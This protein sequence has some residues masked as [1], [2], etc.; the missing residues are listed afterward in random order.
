MRRVSLA[1][2]LLVAPTIAQS[3]SRVSLTAS[4]AQVSGGHADA[5][6]LS[7]DGRYVAFF[8]QSS[9]L[10]T[11]DANNREDVFVHDRYTGAIERLSVSNA[12]V[13]GNGD[14]SFPS[15]S[16]DG[17]FV[18]F[19]SGA[20][21]FDPVPINN[22]IDIYLR[23]RQLGTT[24]LVS[25][26]SLG[27]GSD[28]GHSH[29]PH[30]SADGLYVAFDSESNDFVTGD[31]NAKS[32]IFVH[33]RVTGTTERLSLS[34]AGLQGTGHSYSPSCSGDGSLVAF[35]SLAANL[36]S[37]DTNAKSDI[38][39][40]DRDFTAPT[41][42]RV[43]VTSA[44]A[45]ANGD[46]SEASISA[47]G[48]YVAFQSLAT[49]L[50]PNDSNGQQDIFVRDLQAGTTELVSV[51]N[52]GGQANFPSHYPEISDDGRYVAFRS[53]AS[54]LHAGDTNTADDIYV[55]DRL[56]GTTKH[57]S[58]SSAGVL[59]NKGSD[60]PAISGDG[61][62]VAFDSSATNLV[63]ND[64]NDR[65]DIF[66]ADPAG[67]APA[68]AIRSGAGNVPNS[69]NVNS[70]PLIGNLG[71]GLGYH[72]PTAACGIAP[73][74]PVVTAL[75]FNGALSLPLFSGCGGGSGTL[76]VNVFGPIPVLTKSG[77]WSGAP[78]TA[79]LPLP[80]DTSLCGLAAHGQ[81]FFVAL[82][83]FSIHPTDAV[84]L[85]IGQ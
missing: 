23:D 12:G 40:R 72:N 74:A 39:L 79:S 22:Y 77:L 64:T 63:A 56:L 36:V 35:Q 67:C 80:L 76:L 29:R 45:Q 85:V 48:R 1:C 30:I 3:V 32:D 57:L 53:A 66:F 43:S 28:F 33:N 81:A 10:V 38:F 24:V 69:L 31:N 7:H 54:N 42:I 73:G 18:A 2:L 60:L 6:S 4:G 37:G 13:E 59:A 47:D 82:P 68:V 51:A 71:F 61:R 78:G 52:D 84:D 14:S 49:N 55:R 8:S 26:S 9:G 46:S 65:D 83:A 21:N 70:Q 34:T 25:K 44:G 17:R 50:V 41:T 27:V 20:T 19:Q 16:A 62:F 15:I 11:G 75:D 5:P 58:K